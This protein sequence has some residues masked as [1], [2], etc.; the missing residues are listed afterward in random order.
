MLVILVLRY[1]R[2]PLA[3][4]LIEDFLKCVTCRFQRLILLEAK[5]VRFE[6]FL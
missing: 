6:R 3:L 5:K 1:K 4:S 2:L